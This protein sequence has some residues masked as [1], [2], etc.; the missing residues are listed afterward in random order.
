MAM[1][2][3][4]LGSVLIGL[5]SVAILLQLAVL[6]SAP[7]AAYDAKVGSD[8]A[9]VSVATSSDGMHVYVCDGKRCYS[10]HDN[11]RTF[12]KMNVD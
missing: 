11:G 9:T 2:S 7:A 6:M 12:Q 5:L 4:R 8:S 3:R 1:L 10:S